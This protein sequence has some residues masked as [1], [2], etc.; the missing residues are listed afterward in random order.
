MTEYGLTI[1]PASHQRNN[2]ALVYGHRGWIAQQILPFLNAAF[3]VFL[4][5]K[6]PG[7][8]RDED[9][10]KEIEAVDPTHVFCMIGRTHDARF[11]NIDCN[12]GG[13]NVLSRNLRDN[14]YGPWLLAALCKNRSVHMTY[15]G[16]GCI[17]SNE[18][19]DGRSYDTDRA[20]TEDDAAN[21]RGSSYSVA[22]GD[23]DG[24]MKHMPNV[25]N[26]RWRMPVIDRIDG[27]KRGLIE[28]VVGFPRV[29]DFANSM[30]IMPE[31]LP[32]AVQ[33][34]LDGATGTYNMTNPGAITHPQI[35]ELYRE[36]VD[37]SHSWATMTLEEQSELVVARRSNCI[38]SSDKMMQA[39]GYKMGVSDIYTGM[40]KCMENIA[41]LRAAGSPSQSTT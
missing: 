22:K 30:S 40:K 38:L 8:D 23:L 34:A 32:V 14:L 20:F 33:M 31:L 18:S 39:Y 26:L 10:Q 19:D 2:R 12:E 35:R 17:F 28:K 15:F 29:V 27:S 16:S 11:N 9:V 6:R 13:P 37:P 3:T 36:I 21:F 5:E 4:A 25:L 1:S 24:M 7:D 41:A